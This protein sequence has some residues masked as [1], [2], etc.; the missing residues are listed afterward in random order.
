MSARLVISI[1]PGRPPSLL[2]AGGHSLLGRWAA[3]DRR[4]ARR[5]KAQVLTTRDVLAVREA[6]IREA[7]LDPVAATLAARWLPPD[8]YE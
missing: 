6:R 1:A 3:R 4:C 7:G 2:P 5:R 8:L